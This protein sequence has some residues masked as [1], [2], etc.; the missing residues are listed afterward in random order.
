VLFSSHVY[1]KNSG[2]KTADRRQSILTLE[3]G[4]PSLNQ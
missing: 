2:N 3:I 4:P 1:W